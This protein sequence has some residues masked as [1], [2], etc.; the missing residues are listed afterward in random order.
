MDL[1][2][3]SILPVPPDYQAGSTGKWL[4]TIWAG[5][6]AFLMLPYCIYRLRKHG[7]SVALFAWLG[8]WIVWLGE[9]MLDTMGHLWWPTNLPGPALEAWDLS[10]PFLIPPCYVFFVS[11]TGYFAYRM[12]LRGVTVKRVFLVW[13]AVAATDL[14]L[15]LPGTAADVYRYYGDQ[16]FAIFDFP[17]HWGWMNGTTMVSVGFV[18]WLMAPRLQGRNRALLLLAPVLGFLGAY[19]IASWPMFLSINIDVS[20]AG[21]AR[22]RPRLAG[23]LPAADP[24]HGC[25]GGDRRSSAHAGEP[26]RGGHGAGCPGGRR[27]QR[28]P[29][30]SA[31]DSGEQVEAGDHAEHHHDIGLEDQAQRQRRVA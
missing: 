29:G 28:R 7:D 23:A 18:L 16:P 19:G 14:A 24:R 9:P 27:R 17:M 13:L 12:F 11:M 26:D 15:E 4:F 30:A 3:T 25:G 31:R 21:D 20:P 1:I 5:G 6:F 22:D 10:V 2:A 8:G